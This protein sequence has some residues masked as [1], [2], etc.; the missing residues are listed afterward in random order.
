MG[1]DII[2]WPT[3]LSIHRSWEVPWTVK[4]LG[5]HEFKDRI[6]YG[7]HLI[8]SDTILPTSGLALLHTSD[9]KGL[10]EKSISELLNST[11]LTSPSSNFRR[12]LGTITVEIGT[13]ESTN[14]D[15]TIL[16]VDFSAN[17]IVLVIRVLTIL[18]VDLCFL[19]RESDHRMQR[20]IGSTTENRIRSSGLISL[21][22]SLSITLTREHR[23]YKLLF[24]CH[25]LK[26]LKIS[27]NKCKKLNFYMCFYVYLIQS[28]SKIFW[29]SWNELIREEGEE[30]PT[31]LTLIPH[32]YNP[33]IS[34][35][36]IR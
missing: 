31:P 7:A 2:I 36:C 3:L 29:I 6:V 8:G 17:V 32:L 13:H 18:L 21:T 34:E 11:E 23:T 27:V 26:I 30:C 9:L 4:I 15:T 25:N 35:I 24:V 19:E 10:T 12:N 5:L 20:E 22:D 28:T 33:K 14:E 16:T 1:S